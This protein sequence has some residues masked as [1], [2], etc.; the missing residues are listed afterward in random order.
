MP[1]SKKQTQIRFRQ[2]TGRGKIDPDCVE[3][4]MTQDWFR[5]TEQKWK[6]PIFSPDLESGICLKFSLGNCPTIKRL[7]QKRDQAQ[8][9]P[10]STCLAL[11]QC[12]TG[13]FLYQRGG[14]SERI[15]RRK[16]GSPTRVGWFLN[17]SIGTRFLRQLSPTGLA[18]AFR[19]SCRI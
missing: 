5:E 3:S 14:L 1:V 10:G 11:Y 7:V 19:F 17:R 18:T 15:S 13:N 6:S 9:P 4:P 12:Q 16:S 8:I 2:E